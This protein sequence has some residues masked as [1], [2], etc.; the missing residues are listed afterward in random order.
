MHTR[1]DFAKVLLGDINLPVKEWRLTRLLGWMVAE[2]GDGA[3]DGNDG[4]KFNPLNTTYY[5][6]GCTDYNSVGV[7][8]YVSFVSGT[9][10][11]GATLDLRYY[12]RI[13][14]ALRF[15]AVSFTKAVGDSPWGTSTQL[16]AAGIAAYKSKPRYYD[17]LT[18]G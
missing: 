13:R 14:R 8:N 7:K 18:V 5:T 10:A 12:D 4:A 3:C 15:K 6:S 16:C 9:N 1:R 17:N 11:T 2:S